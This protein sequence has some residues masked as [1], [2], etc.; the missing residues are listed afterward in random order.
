MASSPE[1]VTCVRHPQQQTLLRCGK[2]A[3]PICPRCLIY[4][5]VGVR[6]PKC[7]TYERNPIHEVNA[8]TLVKG[9]GAGTGAAMAGGALWAVVSGVFYLVLITI[10]LG[11]GLGYV[12]GLAV[13]RSTNRK[14]A[15]PLQFLA[16]GCAVL[17]FLV[18]LFVSPQIGSPLWTALQSPLGLFALVLGV[19]AAVSA[20]R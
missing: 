18:A 5:P 7:V 9:V 17:A 6:C 4:T 11:V 15:R 3:D 20:V 8:L 13:S 10:A 16:G 12:V 1:A 14:Q 2:C 19:V